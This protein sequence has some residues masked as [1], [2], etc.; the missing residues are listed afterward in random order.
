MEMKSADD[1]RPNNTKWVPNPYDNGEE[2]DIA[3]K[4]QSHK[5]V[6]YSYLLLLGTRI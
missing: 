1:V 4:A 6:E 2:A 5:R 3:G